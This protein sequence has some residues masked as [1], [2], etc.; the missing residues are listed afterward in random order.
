MSHRLGSVV[1]AIIAFVLAGRIAG[2][3]T[4]TRILPSDPVEPGAEF[5]VLLE[6]APA[7]GDLALA[8]DERFPGDHDILG[9]LL[10]A[11]SD[12]GP[13]TASP[14]N[15]L[16]YV[17][18][19]VVAGTL[20]YSLIAPNVPGTYFWKTEEGSDA[21][22][23]GFTTGQGHTIQTIAGDDHIQVI[24]EPSTGLFV[25]LLLSVVGSVRPSKAAT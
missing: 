23:Y 6:I 11:I 15:R 24:P 16:A 18:L 22:L 7:P 12:P 14:P 20:T 13:L 5:D 3:G 4:V 10:F 19:D 8:L 25:L 2:A 21:N 1:I 17:E 9:E